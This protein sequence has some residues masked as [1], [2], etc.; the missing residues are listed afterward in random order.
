MCADPVK[1]TVSWQFKCRNRSP[2]LPPELQ[3]A[4]RQYFRLDDAADD[5]LSEICGRRGGFDDGRHAGE[6]G[7]R[8]FLGI[9]HGKLKA[10]MWMAAP[11]RHIEMLADKLPPLDKPSTSPSTY[12]CRIRQL[13]RPLPAKANTVPTMPPSISISASFLVAPVR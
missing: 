12:A 13:T 9:P 1:D 2:K 10:L 11:S 4:L 5:E 8:Q 7:R 6:Q 3:C